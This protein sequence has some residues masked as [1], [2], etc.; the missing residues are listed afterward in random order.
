VDLIPDNL[1]AKLDYN[2]STTVGDAKIFN[3]N[4]KTTNNL[5][6]GSVDS[7]VDNQ[8]NLSIANFNFETASSS[9]SFGGEVSAFGRLGLGVSVNLNSDVIS[10]NISI[11]GNGNLNGDNTSSTISA[12]IKPVGIVVATL[13]TIIE[14]F[15]PASLIPYGAQ[16]STLPIE[17]QAPTFEN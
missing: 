9:I 11:N 14:R 5:T 4:S 15:V 10:S 13:A 2:T 16:M 1:L 17:G 8:L 6:T 3:S 7:S 12:G